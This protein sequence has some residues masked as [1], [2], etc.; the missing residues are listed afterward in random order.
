MLATDLSHACGGSKSSL[1]VQGSYSMQEPND[2]EIYSESVRVGI[3][4]VKES[5]GASFC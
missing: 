4:L 5:S 1:G 3:L 2:T